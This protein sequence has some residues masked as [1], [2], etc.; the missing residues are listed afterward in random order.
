MATTSITA[1]HQGGM[2]FDTEVSGHHILIDTDVPD[3]GSN[4]GTRPKVLMLISLAGCT[5]LDV[6]SILNKQRVS[7]SGF[8]VQV[9]AHLTE[10]E[11]R[12]YDE[13]TVVYRIRVAEKD[14]KKMERA[15][16]LS[17]D[18]YCGV[19]AMF[20]AFATLHHR[21]EFLT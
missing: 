1:V 12:I 9:D 19:S 10:K 17:Q 11:P 20:R 5:G 15:V 8:S 7:F 13:V 21:I 14:R 2:N 16:Q 3:G 6:V 18:T 4:L